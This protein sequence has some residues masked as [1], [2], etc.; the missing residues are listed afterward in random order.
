L[1]LSFSASHHILPDAINIRRNY[2]AALTLLFFPQKA[3]SAAFHCK[4]SFHSNSIQGKRPLGA[5]EF[6]ILAVLGAQE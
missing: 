6:T 4:G 5:G 1:W 3:I 2:F